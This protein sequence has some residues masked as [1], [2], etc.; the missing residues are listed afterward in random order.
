MRRISISN[1]GPIHD[2]G[3]D[4]NKGMDIIIGPQA[5]G[6]STLGKSVYF[7]KKVRDY[8]VEFVTTEQYF[9]NTHPNEIYI[10]FLK[11]VRKKYMGCFGT[12]RHLQDFEIIY[13]YSKDKTLTIT[14][15][16]GVVYF[17]FSL[18]LE[19]QIKRTLKDV[20]DLY[21][22]RK[23]NT[24]EQ[25]ISDFSSVIQFQRS[26]EQHYGQFA[27]MLFEDDS[28]I[29]YIPAGRSL[30]SVL[31]DQLDVVDTSIMD[32]PMQD[33]IKRIRMTKQNFGTKLDAVV[34]NYVQTVQGQVKNTALALAQKLIKGVLKA[35]YV[36]DSD[37]EK[38]Y[39]DKDQWVKLMYGS[40]GQQESLWILLLLFLIILENR[41]TYVIIEEPEAH[42]Y[43][44]SQ[45]YMMELIAL[46]MNS[47]RSQMFITTHSPYV[48]SSLN[49]LIQ[50]SR[51]ENNSRVKGEEVIVR[52]QLRVAPSMVDAYKI[53]EEQP[54]RFTSIIDSESGMIN[55][56]EIDTISDVINEDT[57]RLIDL[58]IKYDL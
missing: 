53:S 36:S 33:F 50:S 27:T 4:L 31:S 20:Y 14:L 49:L 58:E 56:V 55:S 51:V 26:V 3:L 23:K 15:K 29:I 11:Y 46:T 38:L 30:L 47:S 45:K 44:I 16:R 17:K 28:D 42:L 21:V 18:F 5:S 48:L 35:D 54:F 12:T 1:Y 34:S 9:L 22:E 40:S 43:P 19:S 6:K 2:L 25:Y 52:K 32:L 57:M 13:A 8:F 24:T 10:I 39:F 7:C 37:G 41:K